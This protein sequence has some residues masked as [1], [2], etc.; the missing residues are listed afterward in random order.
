MSAVNFRIIDGE[1]YALPHDFENATPQTVLKW[2]IQEFGSD[3][4]LATGFGAEGCVLVDMVARIDPA[5]RIFYLDT[6]L[7]FPETY[8]LRDQLAERY[9]VRFERRSAVRSL[10]QQT[11]RHGEKLWERDP[12]LCCRLRKVEPLKQM[13]SGLRAWITA[14]RR[15]QSPARANAKVVDH[16][17]KF[18]II[19]VNPLAG[20]TKQ[21]VWKYIVEHDVPYNKLHDQGYSSIGCRPCTTPVHGNEDQRAG[22]WRGFQKTECGLHQ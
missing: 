5:T 18:G 3:V 8:T 7:L 20:W 4:A 11:L 15:D 21:Q 9:G 1:L 16:D 19:K 14:I 12:D 10:E 22:R 13:L 17:A 2:A 6:D